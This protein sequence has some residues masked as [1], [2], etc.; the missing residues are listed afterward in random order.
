MRHR[1]KGRKLGRNP[2]HQRALLRNLA[3]ALI[4]TER[5]AEFDDNAPKVKGRIVTTIA[6]AKE[7]R[8]LVEKCITIA[9]RSLA[10]QEAAAEH[11]TSADRG[12]EEWKSWRTSDRWNAWANAIAPSVTARRRCIQLLGDKQAVSIL[13]DEIAPRFAD[14][15][16]GYTR[17]VRLAQPRLG[18]AGTR[19]ILEFVGVRDRVV[20]RSERPSFDDSPAESAP[21]DEVAES[22]PESDSAGAVEEEQT[23]E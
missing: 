12:S 2:N 8:P 4:L 5:D 7:V 19:A 13:F 10:A 23:A 21:A 22:A 1:N 15:P 9:R 6:K 11:S 18:D 14:R 3:S 20:E 17:I 16:G